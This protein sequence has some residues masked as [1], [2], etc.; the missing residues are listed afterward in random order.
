[1][2]PIRQTLFQRVASCKL[3]D[4]TEALEEFFQDSWHPMYV[5]IRAKGKEHAEASELVQAFIRRELLT[6]D[7]VC[8]WNPKGGRLRTF[9]RPGLERF[10]SGKGH[11]E[12]AQDQDH[13]KALAKLSFDFEW[14][15]AHY[16]QLANEAPER[17]FDREWAEMVV[18][19]SMHV[20]EKEYL[21]RGK[22][23][24]YRLL[25]RSLQGHSAGGRR[26]SKAELA[27]MLRSTESSVRQKLLQ[28]RQRHR[29]AMNNHVAETVDESE[30][31]E[32][33]KYISDL[34]LGRLPDE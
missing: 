1:M 32:E 16:E 21:H 29:H 7:A 4:S 9:V 28:L 15:K 11:R 18:H 27:L 5:F 10:C 31:E 22:A 13:P 17:R 3:T 2:T 14:S 30:I 12:S 19:K 6:R 23:K 34:A 24:E 25:N 20:V 8:E 26:V 33:I